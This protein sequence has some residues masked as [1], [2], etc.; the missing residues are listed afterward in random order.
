LEGKSDGFE[1]NTNRFLGV[2]ADVKERSLRIESHDARLDSL[3]YHIR[4]RYDIEYFET[5]GWVNKMSVR[6]LSQ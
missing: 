3:K 4:K 1:E 5:A 6:V 2:I